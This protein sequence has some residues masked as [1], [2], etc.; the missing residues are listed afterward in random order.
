M[1]YKPIGIIHSPFKELKGMP[2]Q[3]TGARGTKGTIELYKEYEEGLK[4]LTGFSH[5]ILLYNFHASEGYSLIVTPFLDKK[6]H[7][8]FATRAPKRPNSIGL[9]IVK[10]DNI[11]ENK[12]YISDL[13][14]LDKTP[15]LDIKPYVPDFDR[16]ENVRI[17]WMEKN[18]HKVVNQKADERFT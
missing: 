12:L 18:S 10:L 11:E 15:L 13:D 7:G 16:R 14:I 2:I 9:S 3:P 17:G 1:N 8:L 6:K 4:D 5:I